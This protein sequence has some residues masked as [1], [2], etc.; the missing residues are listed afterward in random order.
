MSSRFEPD[1]SAVPGSDVAFMSAAVAYGRRGLGLTAPNPAVG[2]VIVRDGVIVGRG[3]T[4]PGGRPHAE[5]EALRDASERARGATLYVSLEPCSHYGVTP[6]CADAIVKA[7]L[8]R[9]VSALE[10]PDVRV[11][12]RGH[13]KIVAA[14]IGLL[15]GVGSRA[16]RRGNLGHILRVTEG[17]PMVTLKL[18]ETANGL[19]AGGLHDPRLMITGAAANGR[20]QVMRAMHDAIMV[21]V[22]TAVADDPLLTVRAPGLEERRP[23]RIVL[24][25]RLRLPLR[26]RL[27][28]TAGE[29]KLLVVAS[30]DASRSAQ[31]AL[32]AAGVEVVRV[33]RGTA[34][35]LDLTAALKVL[36]QRGITRVFAEG[37][38]TVA[39]RLLE[40]GLADEV[41][42]FSAPKPFGGD[43]VPLLA[44][45]ARSLLEGGVDYRIV[46]QGLAGLDRF[47]HF[48]RV[49]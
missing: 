9:V 7:G 33:A 17:R 32:E 36:G 49:S 31:S 40:Q 3:A 47:R 35:D 23:L 13:G 11:A 44:P 5:T 28:A 48:E 39:S 4:M 46:E 8:A 24:D 27:V 18:A 14:G 38:P 25:S 1:G 20:V 42:L 29:R 21:G 22:G 30:E 10:D 16:A 37:G 41:V 12:G 19:A 15:T 43:G 26:S 6:P 34:G 45:E 2:C